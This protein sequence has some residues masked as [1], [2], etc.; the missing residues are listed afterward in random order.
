[1]RRKLTSFYPSAVD[2]SYS[3]SSRIEDGG[4][5]IARSGNRSSIL[6]S[7]SSS[8][9]S[10]SL[11]SDTDL[12]SERSRHDRHAEGEQ[13]NQ[14]DSDTGD[15]AITRCNLVKREQR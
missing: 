5:R 14:D 1:M 9:F 8:I 10:D 4:L 6:N 12:Q 3:G 11:R 7:R 15:F 13:R 2:T